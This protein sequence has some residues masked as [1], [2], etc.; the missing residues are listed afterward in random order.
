A[1]DYQGDN[2]RA[3]RT[4]LEDILA[5][6]YAHILGVE[7]VGI[8]DSFFHLGGDSLSAM[9]LVSAVNTELDADLTVR[10]LFEA[11]TVAQLAP[12]VQAGAARTD[13][14]VPAER[15][16]LVPLSFAQSRLWFI[17]QFQGPSPVYNMAVALKLSGPVDAEVMSAALADVVGRHESLRTLFLAPEGTPQQ[18]VVP[19]ERSEVGWQ[20]VDATRWP[21]SW[22]AEATHEAA[23]YTFDLASELPLRAWLF[24]TGDDEHV[25][26]AV[27]HHIAAD[28]W[29]LAPLVR[30]LGTAYASRSSGRAPQWAPLPVQYVDYTLWQRAQFGD[31]DDPDSPIAAQLAYW[32]QAL[33]GLPERVELPTDRPYPLVADYRGAGVAVQWPADL[34]QQIA[35]LARAHH[36]TIFMVVQAGLAVLLSSLSASSDV[37]VGFPIAGRR[38]P[39]LDDVVGFFVNTL[40]LRVDLGG[41]PSVAELLARVRQRSLAAYEHQ[42]VPFEV[43]VERLNPTRDL[44]H[45]PLVQVMLAW[46][47][48][49]PVDLNLGDIQVTP[50]P[51]ETQVARMD[52]VFSLTE[53]WGED[54]RPAG[55]TGTVEFRTDVFDAPSIETMIA[56]LRQVLSAM[57]ADPARALSTIGV[58]AESERDRLDAIG[59][60]AVLTQ[61]VTGPVSI[62]ALFDEQVTHAPAAVA[63]TCG[64]RSWTYR[65]VDA[66][67]NQLARILI[68]RGAGPGQRV[69]VAMPRSAGA[70]VAILA[71]LKTGAAY[72]PIDPA[73][74]SAR[75][76][77][78]LTDAAPIATIS[79]AEIRADLPRCGPVIDIDDPAVRVQPTTGLPAPAADN[80]AYVIYTSGTTGA[81]K[82]VAVTHHNVT[83]L[84][85]SLDPELGLGRVWSHCHSLAFDFSVWELFG[86]L[87]RGG[88]LVVVP[89][90]VVRSPEDLRALLI[91]EGVEV[92]S[93]TPSAVAA[94]AT[95]GLESVALIVGGEPCPVEVMDR[96]APGRVMINQYGPTETTMY[97]AM[98]APL[99]ADLD[100]VPIGSPV[101]GAALFV[102]DHWLRPVP[103]GVVGEL[104]IAGRG[105]A[106]GYLDRAGL[107]ASRFV[108]CPFG[109]PGARM[110][111]TGDLVRWGADEQLEYLGRA[112]EQVKIR[113]YRIELGEIHSALTELD[114][115]EQ[116]AVIAREDHSA[117]VRLVGYV[118]G[119]ADPT[120]VRSRLAERL[121]AYMVPAAVVTLDALPLTVNG[122]LDTR[123]LPAPNY[124]S[125]AYRAPAD[126]I[127][128][129]LASIYAQAL[130]LERVGVD[131]SFFDLGGDSILSMQVVARARAAGV[132]CRPRDVFVEQ[133]V[134]RLARVVT[135]VSAAVDASDDG[136]GPVVATP[137]MRWLQNMDGPIEQFNQT[138]VLAAPAGVGQADIPVLLQ[139]LLDRHPMLRLCVDDDGAGDWSLHVPEVGAVDACA[140][141][142]TVDVL[143]DAALSQARS[144]LNPGAGVLLSAVWACATNQ[145]ALII[146]HLAVDAVSWRTLV[147]DINIAWA[148]RHSGQPIELPAGG[149]SFARWSSLLADHARSAA[150]L[151]QAD[152]WRRIE[153]TPALLPAARPEDTYAT[154]G[155]LSASLDVETTRSLLGEVPAAFHAGVQ[156]ILLIAFG[157]AIAEFSGTANPIGIDI[158]GHGRGEELGPNV[159]LSRTVGWFTTKHPIALDIP[160]LDWGR[161]R[162][163]DAALSA[164]IKDAKE[165][166]R[167]LPNG[168]TYGLLRYL[169]P[170][171]ALAGSDPDIG[172]NYLGRLGGGTAGLSDELWRPSPNSPSLSAAAAALA[173]PL[174][175]TLELNAGTM[176]T[177]DGPELLANW[178]WA[179]SALTHREAKRLSRLWFEALAGICALVRRGGGGLTPSDI[180][181]ARLSQQQIDQL[182]RQYDVADILPLT[183]LQQGLLFHATAGQGDADVYAVQLNITLRGALDSHRLQRALHT[184]V[185]R[186]P[187]L[188]ARF[189]SD[190]GDP[191][192]IIPGA[193]DLAYQHVEIRGGDVEEQVQRLCTAERVAARKLGADPPLR[194]ALI[195]TADHEHRFLLTVHHIVM[196][197]WSLPILLQEI[198]ACYYGSRLPT[199]LPYR[200]FVTWLADRDVAAARQAWR[201]ALDGFDTP[202]MVGPA[203]RIGLGPRAVATLQLTAETTSALGELARSCRTTVNTVLQAAWAQ[204]LM[205]QTGQRDVAFGTAVSGRPA[206]LPGAESM[207]GLLINTVPVRARVTAASTVADLLGQLQR[208]HNDTLEHQHLALN[209]IHRITG[210]DQLFDS[211]LVYENYPVDATTLSAVH[212]L[213]VTEFTSH[214]Y[215][216]YPLSLQ[217]V[218]GE[219]LRLRVEFD[220]DVFD[221][222][223]IDTLTARLHRLLVAMA[224]DPAR[225]LLSVD[226]LDGGEHA[227]LADWGN[228]AALTGGAAAPPSLP[229]LF[230]TQV[231]RRPDAIAVTCE[232]RTMTYR[233]LDEASNRLAHLLV[234]QGIGPG[235]VVA[236]LFSRSAEAIVAILAALK[237]G[238][239]YLPID[240]ALPPARIGFMI[241][242]TA[243]T[244]AL[245]TTGLR[246]RLAGSGLPVIDIDAAAVHD[247]SGTALPAPASD[248]VAY[249]IYTSGTTGVPK[250]VAVTHR[251]V[252]QLLESLHAALPGAGV[253]SQCHSYGFDVSIQEI[254]GALA[255]G[256]RLV[257]VPEQVTRSPDELHAMLIAESVTVLSQ[258]PSALA[259]LSPQGLHTALIIGGEPC[260]AALAGQWAPGRVMINAYGPTETTVDVVLSAPLA[261]D[262]GAPPLGSPVAG[263]ALFVLDAWLRPVAAGVVGELYVAGAGVA[264]GYPRRAGLTASRFVACPFGGT[265][266]RM[267]RTGDLVR[268]GAD[269]RLR[270]AGRA[271]GQVKIRGHRIELGE[272]HSALGQLDGVTQSAVIAREDRPGEKRLVAYHTGT[273]DPAEI[274]AQL[275]ARL[276]AYMVPSAVVAIE[277]MPLTPNGKI[278]ARALPAPDYTPGE[279]RAPATPVEEILAGIYARVLGLERVGVDD[280]FF[281][282]GGDSLSAMRAIATI[283]TTLDAG[284][285]VRMLFEAPT[286]GELAARVGAGG[287][288]LDG[289]MAHQRPAVLPL[290]FAQSRLWFIDQLHGPSPVYNMAAALRLSG[291]LDATALAVALR[292]VVARHESL[293]TVFTAVEG[294]PQQVVL[295]PE[296]ADV[297]WQDVDATGWSPARLEDAIRHT[298]RHPFDLTTEIP[299]CAKLFRLGDEEH[300]LVAVVHHIAADGGSLPPLVRDLALSY[301]SRAAGQ[302]PDWTPL[303]AQYA[304]Y[305]LWQRARF[306]DLEDPDSPIAKQ[307]AY[308]ERALAGLP[309]RLEL[310]TDRPYPAV[311]DYRGASVAVEWPAELQQRVRA[312]ADAHNATS[313]MVVQAALALLLAKISA[314]SDVAVGFPIAGRRD[315]ALDDVVGFFVNTLVLRV[316]LAGDPTI[317]ELLAQVRRRS[318]AAYEHQDVPFEALVERLNP[319]RS[320]AHHPL[321]QVMLAWQNHEPTDLSLGDLRVTPLPVDTRTARTDVAWSLA[322]R[323]TRDGRPAGIGGAVEFRTDVFDTATVQTL[324]ER[325]RRVVAA[326]TADPARRLSSIDLLDDDEHARLHAIGNRA[327]LSRQASGPS[328]IPAL[329]AAQVARDPLAVALTWGGLSMSYRELDAAANRLAHRLIDEG[330]GPGQCVAVLME[331]SAHAVVAILAVLK[332][333][334]AYLPID[335]AMPQQRIGFMLTDAA[336]VAAVTTTNLRS[337]L[338]G[339][340]VAIIDVAG[341]AVHTRP[342]S[343]LTAP[344]PA[345]IAYLIYTSGTTG[346]PK[347][348]A[349][350]HGNVTAL[351]ASMNGRLTSPTGVWSQCHSLAFDFSVW[352]IF[353]ALLSGGRLLIVP[354]DVVRSP[355]DLRALLIDED[356]SALSQTPS[357]FFALQGADA[358]RSTHQFT[359]RTVVFGGEALLPQRLGKWLHNHPHRPRLINMY[360]IT[361]TTVHASC[362]EICDA[363]I[364]GHVS[365][366]GKPLAHLAFFVLDPWLCAV[367]AGVPG[368]LYVAGSGVAVGYLGRAGLTASRFVACPFGGTGTRMYRTGD[369]MRWGPDGQLHYL[370]RA[371]DQVKIRGHRIELGEIHSALAQLDGVKQAAVIARED[372]PGEKRLVGYLTG[373]ADPAEAR[374]RLA[375]RLPAYMVPAAV[376]AVDAIPLTPN[377]KLDVRALPAPD[378]HGRDQYS[379]PATAVEQT[380][381]DIYA[382]VLGVDRVGIDDSFFDLGGDSLSAMRLVAEINAGLD[383]HLGVRALFEAPTIRRLAGRLGADG[384]GRLPLVAAARP[385]VVPL[386]FAQSRLWFIGQLHGPS[387]VHNM[388]IALQLHGRLDDAAFGAALADVVARHESLRTLFPA[389]EG[390]PQQLVVEAGEA[391]FGWQISDARGWSAAR[392]GKAIDTVVGH[393]FELA[394]ELPLRA[395]L[396]RVDDNEY[397][398]VAVL[399]HIAADGWSLTPL[400]R[401][402]GEAYASR[403]AGQAPGWAPLPVQYVDYTLWQRAQFG[404]LQDPHSLIAGQLRYWEHTLAG[405]PERLELPTDRPYPMVADFGGASVAVEWPAE[406]QQRVRAVANAHNATS[407]MVVQAALA[408]LL[409]KISASSDVAVGFP[410]AGRRDPALDDVVGFF[411]NTLV[412]RV[413]L[414]GDPTVAEV[415]AHVRARSLAAYEHQDVPFEVLVERLNPTRSLAHHPLVQVMLAWQNTDAA[416]LSLGD[417]RVT[418]VPVET[419]TARMDLAWSLAERWTRD[420]RPAGIGG[421][422]EFRTDVFDTATIE[423]LVCRLHRVLTAITA[424]PTARLSSID[425]L[426]ADEHAR[427]DAIGNRTALTRE[428]H[429]PASIPEVFAEHVARA[430]EAVAIT[431]GSC[432][433]T[434]RELDES[435]NRL[436]HLLVHHGAGPGQCV[437]LL[438]ERSARAVAAILAVLKT[439]A[440]YLPIDPALPA[441]RIDFMLTDAAPTVVL[442]TAEYR[443]RS[444]DLGPLVIDI[445]DP[446]VHRQPATP[447]PAPAPQGV[448]YTIYTSGTTGVP[449]GVAVTHGNATQLFASLGAAGLP[450]APGKVW[451][452]CHSLAF[453]FSVW[454]IFGALLHGGR[455]LVVPDEVVR[456]PKDLHALLV[457]ERVDMLT[458]TPS[459]VGMLGTE[460]LES[461]VLAVAGEACP[462]EVVDRWAAGRVMVNVYGPTEITIVAAVSAPLAPGPEAPPIGSPVAGAA[463]FVLDGCLRPVPAGVAGE[464]YVAGAGVSTGYLGRAGLTASRFV[465][466][467]FGGTG[468]RMYRTGDLA[469]W[470]ADGQLRYV[471]R[472]DE[473]VK[474]RGYR[475]ELGEIQAA[476][477][478]LA[479]VERA[480]VIARED[481]PGDKRL[482]GYITGTANPAE[483]RTVLAERLP[484]YMVPSAVVVLPA[485]PLT[486]SG[487]LD[488][489]SLPAPDYGTED[490]LAPATAVEEI[491]AWLY[492]QVLGLERVGVSES[493]FDLGGD[494]LSAMRLVAAIYNA[495]DVHLPVR[496]VF[497]APSVRALSQQLNAEH[498]A[499]EGL[500]ADFASVHGRDAT[501]VYAS[502]LTLDKFIDAPTLSTAPALPAPRGDLRTVLLTGATGFLGRYLVLQWLERLELA[503]GKLICLVRAASDEDA[504]RRLEKTFD[505]GDPALLRYFH[506]LADDHLEVIAGD[507]GR[508]NL[509]VDE[510]TW[511]RLADTV[512]LIVDCAAVV[513]GVL[514]YSELFTPNV[515]GT[516]ELIRLA[517]T[518]KLKPYTYVSTANVGDQIEPAA[519]TEDADVRTAGPI[520][521]VDGSYGNGYGNSKWAGEVLLR[522]ANDLCG[523]PV[524]VF[525]CDMILAATTYR[526]QLNLSDMFTRMVH[527]VVASGVA[528]RSFY[529]LDADG[530]RQRAH[531]DALPVEFVAEAI[532]TLGAQVMDGFETYHVMNPHDDG[533]GL[534]EYVDWLIEAGYPI[535]RVDDFT[536]WLQRMETAL[537]ALPERQRHQSVLQLLQ[538][539]N[540]LHV[541]PADPAR[542]CLGPTERFRAAVQE[543]KIGPDNDIPQISPSV[544]VKYVTDLK[545]LGLL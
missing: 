424:D 461:T 273:A 227:R 436:A 475:I 6:I 127:E 319:T 421:A 393:R 534:D 405:M 113:G 87:L 63:I 37:A 511:Q 316:D 208:A 258:T 9:R 204:L 276:P 133:T 154:A 257:I 122:K 284:I 542:G 373:T 57:T 89:D 54:S 278:D 123:A 489:R 372:R 152:A 95:D 286:V 206:D 522:E 141:L 11:P 398:L 68:G 532:A 67:A 292:D 427:L 60:R 58:L 409:A 442:T 4:A 350:T 180:A 40:V 343:A 311:A 464:L 485:L 132:M 354:D 265:G 367:P 521:T 114:G 42:D 536:E 333:G 294:I 236:L 352:E 290:S 159:D 390:I 396:F 363:D 366:I 177:D 516:A 165:Q 1:P 248:N 3:P 233:A 125:D 336:P 320:L 5:G 444:G 209:E 407:F 439:G 182:E 7:R 513:N 285:G 12:H 412:L 92:L 279:Y 399:H 46:Q 231:T 93:Q 400:V 457:A 480:L 194:A 119:T 386:S 25:L 98:T 378:Y 74:P 418:P 408:V 48:N 423:A 471:G 214:D 374:A 69:A 410:I 267:Y 131:D 232:G 137:I 149:T 53:H 287:G 197:G 540:A 226:A 172:F 402:L 531:F 118:T 361:E 228:R 512:D 417:V 103:P 88:R 80:V 300:V 234:D 121:P 86:P 330:C 523:L 268:W 199:A 332:T 47:N 494:S 458:Q 229:A 422:V 170:E 297:P 147:E 462:V 504:R 111:R 249:I 263:A 296:R 201:A 415:L 269:G 157:M 2:Y 413:D 484:A 474:I 83:Q 91:A 146:H 445:D 348:V 23:R 411:V 77:F 498:G 465:A 428:A 281:D 347:G 102:L 216:H 85:L 425:V 224:A 519:F 41:D 389:H 491:L 253:W 331:R 392:L 433:W 379:A 321:V 303:P 404:E 514:P 24:H 261:V 505:S 304:D 503:D 129:I 293:R 193:A 355:E 225:P 473:Q 385:A 59:N 130:G 349:V 518:T 438:V 446:E 148:Q 359:P 384:G 492:A 169:N 517:V 221:P 454:E 156:D 391:D 341:A 217:A 429:P 369:V 212:D 335:P 28:G 252:A 188:A 81:P 526:G 515:A 274:R 100:V 134:S 139:A 256:S 45:H 200:G 456:S 488:I 419:R 247:H 126:A 38:D 110:Y 289:L 162:A 490:Y 452:Q 49:Q 153:Q 371:D 90:Q 432:S 8:D 10:S 298:A 545:L 30:D 414:A 403:V 21:A 338:D 271:D 472:A 76:E 36:V 264:V 192:Q 75:I 184:V 364:D 26:V 242:D 493:F 520:R 360:G 241:D 381:A 380:I 375:E 222:A 544:I 541:P 44:A 383:V 32:E 272:V 143:S 198:F 50:L 420:G 18:A 145:L 219:E 502:D 440:A 323:W 479:G 537:H 543:A 377:G 189:C 16:A 327:A 310:P 447:L 275:A 301:A 510:P 282:L 340:G 195:R 254:W 322:E 167:A 239:A 240:P 94:L 160:G 52:L 64:R 430:P 245:S 235:H 213:T 482:V 174:P 116:A 31:L 178:T 426:G 136:T 277:A 203:G 238:A 530:N 406:L 39:A 329:F 362:R 538:L 71:V 61:P 176:E 539:R 187:N 230:A 205:W 307:L 395:L 120:E 135:L 29:S 168:V 112:D 351:L 20:V 460:G 138:L 173:L 65:E 500:R 308:W 62:P 78:M 481:R 15:P 161:V 107:T 66:S 22:L 507:K 101:P 455:V 342:G 210:H 356:V 72:V 388:A 17:D 35:D 357:A 237:A 155:Q 260:P 370:G 325:L 508:A 434:Y 140:C 368:E 202:T 181:P 302:A 382:H 314:S 251:N 158:E 443:S 215:N 142:R 43:L 487:K 27:V 79:T 533:I 73:L 453:D 288:R 466:C 326:M 324:I 509:G 450:A 115:V 467:P 108:A 535:E 280:S 528:P 337:R 328:S 150:V 14:L 346:T 96:W 186:H 431:D 250:G 262:T 244:V 299:L 401:D 313:F 84:L 295:P 306:G 179:P 185:T 499:A 315:P 164:V 175:H 117:T 246:S 416:E 128:E 166:L 437:A 109:G 99:T 435:A 334:A 506:E 468:A 463:L 317:A 183:P 501:E 190:F 104:Y 449:K 191:V 483:I 397:L 270:Y 13:R 105:V 524:S 448:A 82:G 56:R 51:L 255:G 365:P 469:W 171:V 19:P 218:P 55:I 305:T 70:I 477:A 144:R 451:S 376:V 220:T 353:G 243:P 495:L 259:A 527:S 459:E 312:V 470:G 496:A 97:A 476:L 266:T 163:G 318:L 309:E 525:R 339:C 124:G 33:A 196:D 207:V 486:P 291:R 358:S 106:I 441:A 151:D 387:P 529:A 283:N 345:D 344:E 478:G 211:L 497:E 34:Q 394:T 223:H